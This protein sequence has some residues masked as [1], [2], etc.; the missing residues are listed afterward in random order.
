[1]TKMARVIGVAGAAVASLTLLSAPA[2]AGGEP[3]Q[4]DKDVVIFG[5]PNYIQYCHN[6][7]FNAYPTVSS[8]DSGQPVVDPDGADCANGFRDPANNAFDV[9]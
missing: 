3:E 1:M 9:D 8:G 7:A 4:E 6:T 2:I 5:G